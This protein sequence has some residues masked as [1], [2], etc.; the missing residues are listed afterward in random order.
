[1]NHIFNSNLKKN[2]LKLRY[3]IYQIEAFM[4]KILSNVDKLDLEEQCLQCFI[5]V[6]FSN[7]LIMH[8][9][10]KISE[11]YSK[12]VFKASSIIL[13][14]ENLIIQSNK[15][16]S[17]IFPNFSGLLCNIIYTDHTQW[18]DPNIEEFI[19]SMIVNHTHS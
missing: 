6:F 7:S 9:N 12:L 3:F 4:V 14:N 1:M 13:N 10:D 8:K 5:I 18:V 19:S 17:K 11:M 16:L 15:L 2:N